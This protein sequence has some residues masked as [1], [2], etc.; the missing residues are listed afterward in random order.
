MK[1]LGQI[2]D[3]DILKARQYSDGLSDERYIA[4]L[5]RRT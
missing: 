5:K 4:L 2:V 1:E 3:F